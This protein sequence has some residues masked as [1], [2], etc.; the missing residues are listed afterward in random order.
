MKTASDM[1]R[2]DPGVEDR[3]L[4]IAMLSIHSNPMGELGTKDTG[5]MSVYIREL[6]K[7]LGACGHTID[8]YTRVNNHHRNSVE[9]LYRNV[10][11]IYLGV[12]TDQHVP[13]SALYRYMNDFNN[14]LEIYRAKHDIA[15]DLIHSHYWLSGQLGQWAQQLWN[16]PHLLM[17]HTLGIV[18][19][20][21]GIGEAE[22][23][24]RISTE[25]ELARAC[26]RI[27]APTFREK[28]NLIQF[29]FADE[30][31]IGVV[32][33]GVNLD[34]FRPLDRAA[35]RSRL[36]LNPEDSII[37]FVGRFDPLKGI[38][39]LFLAMTNLRHRKNL[40]LVVIGGDGDQSSEFQRLHGMSSELGIQE[41]VSFVGRVDQ[42]SLP[43]YYSAADILVVPSHYESFGLVGLE[44][45]ACG[46]PVVSTRVGVLE[47]I[48]EENNIGHL[49]EN[50]T[51]RSLAEGIEKILSDPDALRLPSDNIRSAVCRFRWT[52]IASTIVDEYFRVLHRQETFQ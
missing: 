31:R 19:N 29:Y 51:P 45:L 50:T 24:L 28:Q 47:D 1:N 36:G 27:L 30:N 43:V 49:V 5:G 7:A 35:A 12:A 46:T 4:N 10:R 37:L 38:D 18:K 44:S 39:R 8:I 41:A 20:L 40:Q 52:K 13:K 21:T 34:L 33:C 17:F 25:K 11:L 14:T 15:Y 16:I 26:H 6:A 3:S 22:S 42:K 32:P 23:E 9:T 2:K 48:L